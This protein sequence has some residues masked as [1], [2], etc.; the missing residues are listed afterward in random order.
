ML[1]FCDSNIDNQYIIDNKT[2]KSNN[3]LE[4]L[5]CKRDYIMVKKF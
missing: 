1:N 4:A 2:I 5:Y 3:N